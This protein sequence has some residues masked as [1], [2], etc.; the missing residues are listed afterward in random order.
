MKVPVMAR[1]T[2][3]SAVSYLNTAPLIWGMVH[4]PQRGVFDLEFSLP[5]ECAEA[6]RSGVVDIGLVPVVALARQ[7]DLVVLP[8][9]SIASHGPVRSILLFS[10]KPMEAIETLAADTSS[11]TSV[12]LAQVILARKFGIRPRVRPYPPKLDEMLEVADSALII[13]DPALHLDPEMREWRG[14]PLFVYDLGAEWTELTSLPMV[15]AVW[16]VKRL[17]ADPAIAPVLNDSARYGQAHIDEIVE[18]ESN[19]RNLPASRVR[20]YLT[21]HIRYGFGDIERQAMEI[22]LRSAAGLGLIE[23]RADLS[24][25]EEPAVAGQES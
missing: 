25:L 5:S 2:K 9:N 11:R 6:L 15:F 14:Q 12:I 17:V 8:G 23:W 3:I 24:Y 7:P 22:F 16:A 1:K 18:S 20:E 4:G 13:G 21:S 10:L 19:N